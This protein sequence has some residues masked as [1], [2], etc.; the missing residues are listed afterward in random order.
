[1]QN[2]KNHLSNLY[3]FYKKASQEKQSLTEILENFSQLS[4]DYKKINNKLSKNIN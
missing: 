4:E 3:N 2:I 1:M